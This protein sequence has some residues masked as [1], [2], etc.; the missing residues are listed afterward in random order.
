MNNLKKVKLLRK[1]NNVL[2]KEL[3]KE[4]EEIMTDIVC[5]LRFFPVST[6]LQETIRKDIVLMLLNGERN[7]QRANEVLGDDYRQFCDNLLKELPQYTLRQKIMINIGFGCLSFAI[8]SCIVLLLS[9]GEWYIN[10]HTFPLY[11]PISI[12]L[13]LV[14][15]FTAIISIIITKTILKNS[16]Q[17]RNK[18]TILRKLLGLSLYYVFVIIIC[19][20]WNDTTITLPTISWGITTIILFII[21]RFISTKYPS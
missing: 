4:N 17:M 5:Y 8:L 18:K 19:I 16:F 21:S 9:I 15:G 11:I 20:L 1:E 10:Y 3:S 2:E 13:L 7:N 6:V 12:S 14:M